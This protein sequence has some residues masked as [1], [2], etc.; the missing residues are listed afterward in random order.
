M[1][2]I[3]NENVQDLLVPISKR[4]VNGLKIRES[5]ALGVFVADL[6]KYPV[7]SYEEMSNKI[8]EGY[9]NRT[10]GSTLKEYK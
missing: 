9:K 5:K 10:I 4:P 1:L 6:I 3:Y 2:E 8:D 7:S